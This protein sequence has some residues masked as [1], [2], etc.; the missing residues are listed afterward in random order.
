MVTVAAE[1][2]TT[3]T[4]RAL[5][6]A[7]IVVV[8]GVMASTLPQTAVLGLVPLK[9]LLKNSMHLSR[10]ATA[11]FMFWTTLPWYIKPLAGLVQDAFPMFG[12]RRRSYML[13]GTVLSTATWLLLDITPYNY[14]AYLITALAINFAMM[15]TL[16]A[17][18]GYM[19]EM[20]RASAS[21]GRLTSVR[22]VVEQASLLISGVAGGY[23]AGIDFMWTPIV[24]GAITFL[25]VPIA[26]WCLNEE[27]GAAQTGRQIFK[28]AGTTLVRVGK[29]K[30]L[31]IAAAIALLFY[32]S[33]G[34]Q[35]AQ[36]YSQQN[37]LHFTTQQQGNLISINGAFGVLSAL[38]YGVYAAKRFRL[39]YL[40]MVCILIGAAGQASYFFYN[41]YAGARFID[42][43]NGFGFTLAEVVM[44]HLAVRATPAGCESLGFAIM[45]A[46][47]NF[48][49]YGGDWLGATLQDHFHLSFHTL[50]VINGGGSLLAIP[51][52]LLVPA[53]IIM[54]RDGDKVDPGAAMAA[55]SS[56]IQSHSGTG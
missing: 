43:F 6:L 14:R 22:N 40:L 41:S 10:E 8:V 44:M 39:K 30:G 48:G 19:V 38:L 32:F 11:A 25:L 23:L 15:V 13:V 56:A 50:A 27:R 7:V 35:T 3:Q 54:G 37:D 42:S 18:G 28:S 5:I 20:A 53:A 55:N 29:A 46:V 12:S 52:V 49:L 31:W 21:S 36:F 1:V 17:V 24:C 51:L 45:M 16:T 33:P 26:I 4:N 34:I 2:P 47:R 9:N